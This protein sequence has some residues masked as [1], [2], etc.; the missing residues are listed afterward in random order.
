MKALAPILLLLLTVGALTACG[1]TA[2]PQ[3]SAAGT[4]TA[5][6]TVTAA[7]G[8]TT[9]AAGPHAAGAGTAVDIC[10]LIPADSVAMT[11]GVAVTSATPDV[12]SGEGEHMCLYTDEDGSTT[13]SIWLNPT[14]GQQAYD[15]D[16]SGS[17]SSA[18]QVTG[19]G[20]QA[21]FSVLG[22]EAMFGTTLIKVVG[23]DDVAAASE[24]A[25][26]LAYQL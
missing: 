23:V 2:S 5:A 9:P 26:T 25:K 13:A 4:L 1:S 6:G 10:A 12:T 19:V 7:T 16:L 15:T 17:G 8:P 18:K 24:L 22:L 20:D 21:F 3:P 11:G 14:T